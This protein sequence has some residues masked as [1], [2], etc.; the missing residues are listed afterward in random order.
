MTILI[1]GGQGQLGKALAQVLEKAGYEVYAL[2]RHHLDVSL[3]DQVFSTVKTLHPTVIFHVAAWT[4]VD[5]CEQDPLRA[6]RIHVIGTQNII[7][8]AQNDKIPVW[9]ASTDYVFDGSKGLPYEETDS[10]HPLNVYGK[11]KYEAEGVVLSYS[12]GWVV[13]TSW[14]FGNGLRNFVQKVLSWSQRGFLR[15]VADQV[16][17]PTYT[18]DLAQAALLFIQKDLPFGLYHLANEGA[19]TRYEWARLILQIL[20]KKLPILPVCSQEFPTPAPRPRATPLRAA[21]WEALGLPPFPTWEDATQRYLDT[22]S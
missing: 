11:T 21:R 1:T 3:K 16:G 17:S 6:H 14:L 19:P 22:L 18:M 20:G 7:D 10:P 5:A 13:R 15:I 8:V 2:G 4:D 9:M 12:R